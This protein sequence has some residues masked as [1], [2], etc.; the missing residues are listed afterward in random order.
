MTRFEP[1]PEALEA[2]REKV[3]ILTG[4]STGIGEA[5]VR[6]LHG[7]GAHVAFGDVNTA[8]AESLVA[9]LPGPNQPLFVQCNASLYQ[10]NVTLFKRAYQKFGRVDHAIANAGLVERPGWFD[11]G[12]SI[13]DVEKQPSTT[14]MDV[15]LTGVLFFARVACAYLSQ[16]EGRDRSL[17]LLS[18]VAGFEESPGLFVYQAA[19]HGVL[20][21]MRALRLYA[22]QAF[23]VRVNCVCPWMTLTGMVEGIEGGWKKAGLPMNEP[24]DIARVVVGLAS[25]SPA[26]GPGMLRNIECEGASGRGLEGAFNTSGYAWGESECEGGVNGRA[27]YVEGGKG[28]DVE[29]GLAYTQPYWLGKG[30]AER[31]VEGQK[32]LGTGGDWTN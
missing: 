31:L 6:L 19:K 27:I 16:G 14:V 20:G 21:L 24:K 29:E 18:S 11:V 17:T 1:N 2:L 25:A 26:F 13:E 5:T 23:G 15:N 32:E 3:V 8:G 9:S 28:W 22:P 4:G 30:P 10:D 7:A 12:M